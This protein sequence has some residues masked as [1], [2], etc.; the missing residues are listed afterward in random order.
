[1]S[2]CMRAESDDI[3]TQMGHRGERGKKKKRKP[4]FLFYRAQLRSRTDRFNSVKPGFLSFS[5]ERAVCHVAPDRIKD[6]GYWTL[7]RP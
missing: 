7:A 3:S 2:A 1:M 5:T 4:R 6:T